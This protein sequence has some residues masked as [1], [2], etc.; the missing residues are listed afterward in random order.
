MEYTA[1]SG[2]KEL[3]KAEFLTALDAGI[4]RHGLESFFYALH[5]S[6]KMIYIAKNPHMFTLDEIITKHEARLKA[7]H[8]G[9]YDMYKLGDFALCRLLVDSFLTLALRKNYQTHYA[10]LPNLAYLPGQIIFMMVL[11]VSNS[12]IEAHIINATKAFD[13]LKLI[14]FPGENVGALIEEAVRLLHI[15]EGAYSLPFDASSKLLSKTIPTTSPNYNYSAGEWNL[16]ICEMEDSV[17]VSCDPRAIQSHSHYAKFNAVTLAG[18]LLE[19]YKKECNAGRWIAQAPTLP[20]ANLGESVN[21]KKEDTP[22]GKRDRARKPRP[23]IFYVA[24][25]DHSKPLS[26]DG[27]TY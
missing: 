26:K 23:D 11:D 19:L 15:M 13:N 2:D 16:R 25:V 22:D 7:T 4:R 6:G 5:S 9:H 18:K 8:I 3:D 24:P 20:K 17:G 12:S 14:D 10:H 27:K 1:S 21:E